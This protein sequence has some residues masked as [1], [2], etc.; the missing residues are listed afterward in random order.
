MNSG[1][2]IC[3]KGGIII[4]NKENDKVLGS[5]I[6]AITA[7]EFSRG[8]DNIQVVQELLDSGVEIIQYREKEKKPREKLKQCKQIREMTRQA[9]CKFIVNDDI[10]IALLVGAD[11]IHVGQ[12]DLPVDEIRKLVKDEMIIGL[13]THTPE[14]V[15]EG[16]GLGADYIG[17]GPVF[18]TTTKEYK[19]E[20]AG[21]E[22]VEYVYQNFNIPF[23]AIGGI[24]RDNIKL[25]KKK[26]ANCFALVTEIVESEN[27]QERIKEL[28]NI[29]SPG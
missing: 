6:Y 13:S 25:V 10:D 23:V 7:E 8:R 20:L 12:D 21:L 28:R 18:E 2:K 11:G 19:G 5:D 26:G 16:I 14:E 24:K 15:K 3:R 27:I 22:F 17:V 9:G 29:I 1:Q 4:I